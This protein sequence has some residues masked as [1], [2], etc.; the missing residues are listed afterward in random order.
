VPDVYWK[1][2]RSLHPVIDLHGPDSEAAKEAKQILQDVVLIIKKAYDVAYQGRVS[3]LT[4]S[5]SFPCTYMEMQLECNASHV[6]V[7]PETASQFS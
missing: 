2:V 5:S 7:L 1:V 3:I 6:Y 4:C